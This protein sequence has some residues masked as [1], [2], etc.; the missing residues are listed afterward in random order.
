MIGNRKF[1]MAVIAMILAA[2]IAIVG[3]CL[4]KEMYVAA[5]LYAFAGVCAVFV[6]GNAF[7]WGARAKDQSSIAEQ[8]K[9]ESGPVNPTP[10]SA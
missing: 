3:Y 5:I 10:P 8:T 2:V 6:T 1:V 7:E 4:D 9:R